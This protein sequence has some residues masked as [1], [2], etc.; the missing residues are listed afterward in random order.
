MGNHIHKN[1]CEID[2]EKLFQI[3]QPITNSRSIT[4]STAKVEEPPLWKEHI[5]LQSIHTV[6]RAIS[7]SQ[8][9]ERESHQDAIGMN[10][11]NINKKFNTPYKWQIH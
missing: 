7:T 2:R 11:Q 10:V 4:N 1:Y 8:T 9:N 5:M 3:N 6:L